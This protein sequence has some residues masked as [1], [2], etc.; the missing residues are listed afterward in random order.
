MF[1]EFFA[2]KMNFLLK[3]GWERFEKGLRKGEKGLRKGWERVKK[4]WE[5]I[6]KWPFL[7]KS[8]CV[9]VFVYALNLIQSFFTGVRFKDSLFRQVEENVRREKTRIITVGGFQQNEILHFSLH[10]WLWLLGLTVQQ[11][12]KCGFLVPESSVGPDW[13]WLG[14]GDFHGKRIS[15][16]G[17]PRSFAP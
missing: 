8:V 6:E 12:S 13:F 7:T 15:G 9:C 2:W 11:S 17:R 1:G 10:I 16:H 3:N 4:G 5:R 14:F